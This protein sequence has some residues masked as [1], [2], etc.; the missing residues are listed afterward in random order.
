MLE[1]RNAERLNEKRVAGEAT[2]TE[3]R[4]KSDSFD[5]WVTAA[6]SEATEG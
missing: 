4:R 6:D 2:S 5:S 1:G 3:R